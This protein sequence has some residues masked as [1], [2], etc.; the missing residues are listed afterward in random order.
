MDQCQQKKPVVIDH[1]HQGVG[2]A[3]GG[4]GAGAAGAAGGFEAP[5]N[6]NDCRLRH[7]SLS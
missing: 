7:A 1:H 4:A 3:G 5:V 6:R 2:G